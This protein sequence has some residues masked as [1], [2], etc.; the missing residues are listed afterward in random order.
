MTGNGVYISDADY[1]AYKKWSARE[2]RKARYLRKAKKWAT[3]SG[4]AAF[5]ILAA[6]AMEGD[7]TASLIVWF[8]ALGIAIK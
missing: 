6:V 4:L 1:E 3:V 8:M 7:I 5:G 2:R